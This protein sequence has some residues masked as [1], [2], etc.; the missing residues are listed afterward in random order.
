MRS[1]IRSLFGFATQV[2]AFLWQNGQMQDLGT[3]GGNDAFAQFVNERS[4]VAG[5]SYTSS[6]PN[7]ENGIPTIDPFLWDSGRMIDLGSLGGINAGVSGL[8]N[9]GQVTGFSDVTRDG[10][11]SHAFLWDRGSLLDLGTLGGDF[12]FA[13]WID[14][15][16][17][18]VGGATTPDNSTLRATR[19]KNGHATNLGSL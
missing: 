13:N 8:N 10:S 12:S 7:P 5:V 18:A 3:L 16:G 11:I 1:R 4:Q 9:R 17:E 2:R 6:V 19:W 15:S 14:D